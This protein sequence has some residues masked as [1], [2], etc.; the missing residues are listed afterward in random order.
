MAVTFS[1]AP[2][3]VWI[4][5]NLVGT[6][7]GGGYIKTWRSLNKVQPKP[8]YMDAAGE[9]AWP[10]P[11][12]FDL[13]GVQGPFYWQV[14]SSSPDDTY[15]VQAFDAEDNLLWEID[16]FDP[17]G[18]G[19]GGNV[20]VYIPIQNYIANNVFVDNSDPVTVAANVTNYVVAPSNHKGFTPAALNPVT[21][22]YGTVGPDIRFNK[23][24]TGLL[25][26]QIT[27]PLFPLASAPLTGD[28]TPVNY[29]RYQC[30][31]SP[32]GETFKNFQFPIC[33]KIK[34]LSNQAMTFSVWAAVTAT[35][36][37]LTAYVFQYF[38]SGTAASAPVRTTIGSLA[39][40]TTWT[41]FV[42]N[43]TVPDVA[44]QSIGTPGLQTDDDALYIQLEMPLGTNCD[45]LF[46]KPALYLGTI[47]P[48][49]DFE[50]YDQI[51]SVNLTPRT[52]D[53]KISYLAYP[54]NFTLNGWIPMNDGS[55]GNVNS[56]ASIRR[57]ADC[58][59]LYKT[60]WDGVNNTWAPVSGGRGATAIADF[61][62]GNTLTL[63]LAL[64]RVLGG[65]GLGSGLSFRALG[66][67]TGAETIS[68]AAMP[69]HNHPG[70]TVPLASTP[71]G[72]GTSGVSAGVS[73]ANTALNIAS[74]GSGAADGNMPP[75]TFMNVYIKL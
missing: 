24:D 12:F 62:A 52:G 28:V 66:Q 19:G 10:N 35:P 7:A 38:G 14:D 33:Q 56:L 71:I 74:Q 1:L 44:A 60:L 6:T 11:T 9:E 13:N 75:T 2:E 47:N 55:I 54:G 65:A 45:V 20:T 64:G 34:N 49:I 23:N 57:D 46:T 43:F 67:N 30:T 27:Y 73:G 36:V 68:I 53:I 39:L 32:S 72:T 22:I 37:N 3:P 41:K 63:P 18:S 42:F 58:F 51:D 5:I 29:I 25:S 48:T 26:D 16:G 40:T 31:G 70:S 8:I 17:T 4:L 61:L 21:T 59:Q 15:F 69:A 50:D